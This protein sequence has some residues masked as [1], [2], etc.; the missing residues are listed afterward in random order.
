MQTYRRYKDL[1]KNRKPE[2]FILTELASDIAK[3]HDV[4]EQK[5]IERQI[6]ASQKKEDEF[7]Q[8][9][10]KPSNPPQ[11][12]VE[13]KPKKPAEVD[14]FDVASEPNPPPAP[15]KSQPVDLLS[16]ADSTSSEQKP[17]PN[18]FDLLGPSESNP[19]P[20]PTNISLSPN[21]EMTN[22]YMGMSQPQPQP[23]PNPG[24]FSFESQVPQ[25]NNF[26]T[27]VSQPF[28]SNALGNINLQSNF[29][30]ENVLQL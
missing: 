2:P 16:M 3:F 22:N 4:E 10:K 21:Q 6:K 27:G 20:Q 7:S 18:V 8:F 13:E 15:P 24:Q 17:A 29:T 12:K 14:I 28:Q 26:A 1:Q 23:Q 25:G 5:K 9:D 19:Q 11:P 30:T